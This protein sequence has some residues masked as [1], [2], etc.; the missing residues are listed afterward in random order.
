MPLII[1]LEEEEDEDEG[2]VVVQ[3][4]DTCYSID[5]ETAPSFS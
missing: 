1:I 3:T 4:V 2:W 5:E